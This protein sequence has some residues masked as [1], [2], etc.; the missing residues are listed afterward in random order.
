ML[1]YVVAT[2]QLMLR[3]EVLIKWP[4]MDAFICGCNTTAYAAY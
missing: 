4:V 3:I 1:L 2:L